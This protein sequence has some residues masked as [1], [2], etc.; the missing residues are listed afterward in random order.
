[1]YVS[2]DPDACLCVDSKQMLREEARTSQAAFLSSVLPVEDLSFGTGSS[3]GTSTNLLLS[4]PATPNRQW[5]HAVDPA[6]TPVLPL[7][8]STNGTVEP[9]AVYTPT[10]GV[11]DKGAAAV[12]SSSDKKDAVVGSG[13]GSGSVSSF[14][15]RQAVAR[16]SS[17]RRLQEQ[18]FGL[19]SAA[20]HQLTRAL[21][22]C[23]D[24]RG[25]KA[26]VSSRESSFMRAMLRGKG[27]KAIKREQDE[28][29]VFVST[30]L[31][32]RSGRIVE[33]RRFT[34]PPSRT[35]RWRW[36]LLLVS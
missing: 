36:R 12:I 6:A 20:H 9:A 25:L 32:C 26:N 17:M 14:A 34:W 19:G 8:H 24:A 5:S 27:G 13:S 11:E 1:M 3:P 30:E 15:D 28:A 16:W 31:N 4:T 29:Q 33:S 10:A 35:L 2:Q 23:R 22:L 18:S 7:R 21:Q